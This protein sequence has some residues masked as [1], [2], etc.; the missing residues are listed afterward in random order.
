MT[1]SIGI[2]I[3]NDGRRRPRPC[4]ATPTPRCTAPRTADG[5]APSCSSP[6]TT[7][8]RSTA[9]RT[10]TDLHRALERDEL[11]V[12][13]QPIANLRTG[14]VVGF[15]ALVRW[16]HPERGLLSPADFIPLAEE[17][18]LIVPIGAWVLETACRQL[19]HWQ[20]R[21]R[22]RRTPGR[23]RDERQPLAPPARRPDARADRSARILA[24]HRRRPE[25]GVPRAH[26]ERADAERRRRR[27]RPSARCAQ[28]GVHLSIDDFGT[29][30]LVAQL[31]QALPGIGPQDRPQLHR[32]ARHATTRTRASS[33]RS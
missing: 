11:V 33:R 32:R 13:Y 8:R 18:G 2:A 23:A 21:T 19:V 10:G 1:A 22:P 3:A 25:R 26:R 9:L 27:P 29:G 17:T 14:R 20:A 7:D 15:E 6:T 5:P 30:L 4:C 16:N 31:P 24:R 28:L 12:H